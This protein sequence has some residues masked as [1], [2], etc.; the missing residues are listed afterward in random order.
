M[1][2]VIRA[3]NYGTPD[4]FVM[5][6]ETVGTPGNNEVKIKQHAIGVNYAD[7]ITRQ[8]VIPKNNMPFVDGYVAAGIIT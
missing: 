7:I 8:G 3:Y 5:E 6:E 1:S 4:V 2:K